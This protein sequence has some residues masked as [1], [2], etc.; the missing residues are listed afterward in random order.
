M[1]KA[2][3]DPDKITVIYSMVP[4]MLM[5]FE[6]PKHKLP[7][8]ILAS[9]I[10]SPNRGPVYRD[11]T[12]VQQKLSIP[13]AILPGDNSNEYVGH[14]DNVLQVMPYTHML[15]QMAQY[16]AGYAG[17]ANS[18]HEIDLCVTNKFWEY[19]AAN[20][21]IITYNASEMAEIAEREWVSINIECINDPIDIEGLI[22]C[23][24]R[25]E[26]AMESQLDKIK[27]AYYYKSRLT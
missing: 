11:Y 6:L 26:L 1:I 3:A 16:S 22:S 15:K 12:E 9:G 8:A 5:D 25:H 27:N 10:S 18:R 20:I 2:G 19:I 17:A 7:M 23:R 13:L 14:Y 24:N 4:R 21:P